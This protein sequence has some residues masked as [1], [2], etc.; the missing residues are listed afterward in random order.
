MDELLVGIGI[1]TAQ[2]VVEMSDD[3]ARAKLWLEPGEDLQQQHRIAPAGN[4]KH[5]AVICRKPGV[6]LKKG[7]NLDGQSVHA[8]GRMADSSGCAECNSVHR[9]SAAHDEEAGPSGGVLI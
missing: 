2:V 7:F 5:T 6:D 3:Q 1:G 9:G 8:V 4:G